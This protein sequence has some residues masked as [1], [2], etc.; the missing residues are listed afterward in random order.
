MKLFGFKICPTVEFV[1][2]LVALKD[3]DYQREFIAIINKL[4]WYSDLVPTG[5][6]PALQLDDGAVLFEST[7]IVEY[8]DELYSPSIYP[9]YLS[10]K[11]LNRTWMSWADGLLVDGY[12]M[13]LAKTEAIFKQ[14]FKAVQDKL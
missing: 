12:Q 9:K 6:V 3:I 5:K 7:I 10:V 8:L 1:D 13:S 4:A 11:A 2:M 14:K